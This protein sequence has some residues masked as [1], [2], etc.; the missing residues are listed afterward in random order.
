MV[1]FTSFENIEQAFQKITSVIRRLLRVTDIGT[2]RAA[3]FLQCSGPSGIK[4]PEELCHN[5]RNITTTDMLIDDLAFFGVWTWIDTRLMEAMA[6][7]SSIPETL[8][9]VKDYKKFLYAKKISEILPNSPNLHTKRQYVDKLMVKLNVSADDVTVGELFN[10]KSVL[11]TVI[12]DIKEGSLTL[13]H[14]DKG[15]IEMHCYIP[16]H[17]LTHAYQSSIKRTHQFS[18][19]HI[20]Y[21]E[22][23]GYV[24]IYSLQS[25]KQAHD[26]L[27]LSLPSTGIVTS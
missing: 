18:S 5:I 10:F 17:F 12:L 8:Q 25:T 4:L 2:I 24:K 9:V 7:A 23:K 14:L 11:E 19:L 13:D 26:G 22:F 1:D 16:I 27:S 3:I 20:R 21:L 6:A 15:C